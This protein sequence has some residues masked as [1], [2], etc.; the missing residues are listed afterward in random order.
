MTVLMGM[1]ELS[2]RGEDLDR[3]LRSLCKA[4]TNMGI[5][6]FLAN[7]VKE[8]E[9]VVITEKHI[10]Y[11]ADNIILMR[12]I[13]PSERDSEIRRR[14]GILKMRTSDFERRVAEFEIT[15]EGLKLKEIVTE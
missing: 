11:F 14:L 1:N 12:Y 8:L 9:E 4:L 5:A 6:V 3:N 7:E 2:I 13:S 10:S 15:N